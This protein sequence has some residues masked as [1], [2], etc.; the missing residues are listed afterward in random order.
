MTAKKIN[1][2][3][4]LDIGELLGSGDDIPSNKPAFEIAPQRQKAELPVES[5]TKDTTDDEKLIRDVEYARNN[6]YETVEA[7]M[8]AMQ[9][10]KDLAVSSEHPRMFEVFAGLSKNLVDMHKE[11]IN[12]H[13]IKKDATGVKGETPPKTGDTNI[14][15]AVFVGT[16]AELSEFFKNNN[17]NK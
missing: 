17:S 6:I 13:K 14:N 3:D 4:E 1:N 10:L 5:E 7:T 16:T 12:I 9:S 8:E 11:L 15:N 2:L